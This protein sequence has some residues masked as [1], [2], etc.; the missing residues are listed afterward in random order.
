MRVAG[1]LLGIISITMILFGAL[2]IVTK[3]NTY[4]LPE[5][6]TSEA[7]PV[8]PLSEIQNPVVKIMKKLGSMTMY[9]ANPKV[10]TNVYRT[11]QM[12]AI[13]LARDNIKRTKADGQQ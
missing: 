8:D 7:Y 4:Y 5:G 12:S 6:F 1:L 13:E 10:W 9:F 2:L 3:N 11:S